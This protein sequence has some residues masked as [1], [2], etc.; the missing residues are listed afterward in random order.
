M[1]VDRAELVSRI[2]GAALL[3]GAFLL[4]SGRTAN[5]YFDKYQFE[6][7]PAL[8]SA[9]ADRLAPLVPAGTDLLGGLELGGVPVATALSLR[10]G[11]P[12]VFVR[13]VA[14][15]YGTAKLAEG[16]DVAGR[17]VLVI[18]DVVTSGGQIVASAGDLRALGATVD[19]AICVVDRGEGGC[20][21]L[22]A[23]GIDLRSLVTGSELL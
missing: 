5:H 11:V 6:S 12:A 18:E 17:R 20:A 3:Q 13:K 2:R 23:I 16:P 8:L 21:A 4:R 7:D 10:T 19:T 1:T 14:K 15:Q 9:I 22:H